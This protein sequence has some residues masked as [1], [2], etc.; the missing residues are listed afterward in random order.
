MNTQLI[1]AEPKQPDAVLLE[2]LLTLDEAAQII[3]RSHWTMRKYVADGLLRGVRI[4]RDLL[5]EQSELRRFI[6]EAKA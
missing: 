3:R 1:T 5:I 2:P 4:G 6:R